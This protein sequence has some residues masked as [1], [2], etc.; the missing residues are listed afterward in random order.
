MKELFCKFTVEEP[1]NPSISVNFSTEFFPAGT[2]VEIYTEK[3]K[4]EKPEK[5]LVRPESA[6]WVRYFNSLNLVAD[7][8][9]RYRRTIA[10]VC[11]D[12]SWIVYG[13]MNNYL[14]SLNQ[15]AGMEAVERYCAERGLFGFGLAD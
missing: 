4:P 2:E 12:G 11:D 8:R 1:A 14:S 13:Q 3:P 7:T 9:D 6:E 10:D 5:K 15:E